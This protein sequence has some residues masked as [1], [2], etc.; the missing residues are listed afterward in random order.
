MTAV[1]SITRLGMATAGISPIISWIHVSRFRFF[2]RDEARMTTLGKIENV[3]SHYD[4]LNDAILGILHQRY[5]DVV[6][7]GGLNIG[8]GTMLFKQI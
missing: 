3:V 8:R 1:C 4:C 2:Y 7:Q 5:L 6:R